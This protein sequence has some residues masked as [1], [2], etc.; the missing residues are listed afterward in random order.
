MAIEVLSSPGFR[1]NPQY[2]ISVRRFSGIVVVTFADAVLAST[3]AARVL[4]EEG[5]KPVY[6]VPFEDIYFEF[7]TR[8]DTRTHCPFK[9]Y[10]SHWNV[11]ASGD[12]EKDVMWAYE[13]PYEEMKIIRN[14]GAFYPQKVRIDVTPKSS[15][16][17]DSHWP[18]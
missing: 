17:L 14:H 1:R 4:R 6:Y 15:K 7:L 12:A 8:S 11:T 3:T 13:E 18:E 5:H 9:G 10:A 16:N 2:H